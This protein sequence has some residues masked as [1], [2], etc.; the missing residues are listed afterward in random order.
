MKDTLITTAYHILVDK[1]L[2]ILAPW[3]LW[4]YGKTSKYFRNILNGKKA[5]FIFTLWWSHEFPP[6]V[7]LIKIHIN[8]FRKKFPNCNFWFLCNTQKEY[9]LFNSLGIKCIFCN[10][11]A[12]VDEKLFRIRPRIR[13]KFDAVYNAQIA[14][15]KRL[16]LA[17][18]IEKLAIITY[19]DYVKSS[20]GYYWKIK[21]VLNRATWI[22]KPKENYIPAQQL[23]K[24]INQARIGLC[25]SK[26]E[27]A[28]YASAEYL[29]CGLPI[30]STKSVGGRDEFFEEAYVK[31]V[32]SNKYAIARAVEEMIRRE[33]SP[34]IIR[35]KTLNK[36]ENHRKRFINLIQG[37][38]RL[39]QINRDFKKEWSK[40]F[41]NKMLKWQQLDP[42]KFATQN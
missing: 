25:L 7:W 24:Y 39:E 5:H 16:E 37:I 10:H 27:G 32:T 34:I 29:L 36:I 35:K 40:R 12:F 20:F 8:N 41:V 2:I 1:P 31:I 9:R 15:F 42:K 18:K 13:K 23:A 6:M 3:N 14:R 4:Y 28:M 30:V 19:F 21:R 11:N 17:S 33:V 22:N 38:Y 26:I